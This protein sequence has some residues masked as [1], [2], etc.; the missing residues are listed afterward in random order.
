MASYIIGDVHGCYDEL[1]ALLKKM[2]F[3]LNRDF[4]IF[5][6]D[7]INRGPKSAE[8][9]DFVYN[10]PNK[11]VLLGNHDVHF[12]ALFHQKT[13]IKVDQSFVSLMQKPNILDL[14]N[15]WRK[16]PL[17][18]YDEKRK[19]IVSHAGIYPFWT[20]EETLA[21]AKWAENIFQSDDYVEFLPYLYSKESINPQNDFADPKRQFRAICESFIRM[22]FCA[23]NGDLEFHHHGNKDE[24]PENFRPWFSSELAV[25]PDLTMFFGHWAALNGVTYMEKVIALDTGCAWGNGLTGYDLDHQCRYF[26][27]SQIKTEYEAL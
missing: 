12:M 8:V 17:C 19:I 10:L 18:Y 9:L 21:K 7:L 6:G 27:K 15:W 2:N 13:D 22:R 25:R 5:T 23:K 20:I 16:C 11:V 3:S 14:I 26:V 24:Y 1:I 4:L